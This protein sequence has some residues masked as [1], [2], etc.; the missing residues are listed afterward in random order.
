M[1]LSEVQEKP[2]IG[3]C[4]GNKIGYITDFIYEETNN[5]LAA[6]VVEE[7]CFKRYFRFFF[8][9][10]EI[11]IQMSDVVNIGEDVILVRHP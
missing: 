6:I 8:Q 3:I 2:V 9:I 1:R 5:A 4:D 11:I 7:M 10:E